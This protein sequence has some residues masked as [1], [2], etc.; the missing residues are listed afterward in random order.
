[1]WTSMTGSTTGGTTQVIYHNIATGQIVIDNPDADGVSSGTPAGTEAKI[2][3]VE[4]PDKYVG[5]RLY[6][7][8]VKSK[9]KK[10]EKE[11]LKANLLRL[12]KMMAAAKE[13][14]QRGV[15]EKLAE[16][17]AVAIRELEAQAAGFE[18]FITKNDVTKFLD[19]VREDFKTKNKIVFFKELSEF[20]RT[21]PDE[22]RKK[23]MKAQ[24][25]KIFDKYHILYTDYLAQPAPKDNK[26]KIREK[27][28]IVFGVFAYNPDKLFHVASWKDEYCDLVLADIPKA[29]RRND[30]DY[31]LTRTPKFDQKF[32]DQIKTEVM[33]RHERLVGTNR[34]NYRDNMKKEDSWWRRIFGKK[35][36][37][38][39]ERFFK[40]RDP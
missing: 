32:F 21:I 37:S 25:A 33:E 35:K 6:F 23:I 4:R 17:A 16:I 24:K 5:V 18:L 27:D 10:T 11:A 20:P 34:D 13:V 22:P 14:N 38:L 29:L 1:M 3:Q 9:F 15:Y 26:T 7:S 40:R 31:K 39:R 2:K 30:P 19:I 28:P 8:L 36:M 12:Q